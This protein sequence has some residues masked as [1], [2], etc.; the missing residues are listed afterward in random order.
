M[1][2]SEADAKKKWCPLVRVGSSYQTMAPA[3]NRTTEGN[4]QQRHSCIGSACM[5]WRWYTKTQITGYCGLGGI[6]HRAD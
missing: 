1:L 6:D 2:T 3:E 4:I 5:M